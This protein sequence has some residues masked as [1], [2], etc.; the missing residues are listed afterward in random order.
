MHLMMAN[1][2]IKIETTTMEH[3]D[4]RRKF[5][6]SCFFRS[7]WVS[8]CDSSKWRNETSLKLLIRADS[9]LAQPSSSATALCVSGVCARSMCMQ[10]VPLYMYVGNNVSK[11]R[12]YKNTYKHLRNRKSLHHI[13]AHFLIVLNFCVFVCSTETTQ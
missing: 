1:F 4:A 5:K 8:M 9:T 7:I 3:R 2:K 10:Y 12:I 13:I 11:N 6:T